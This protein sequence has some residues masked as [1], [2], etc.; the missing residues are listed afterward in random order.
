[1]IVGKHEL[2]YEKIHHAKKPRSR[3]NKIVE[4]TFLSDFQNVSPKFESNSTIQATPLN[5]AMIPIVGSG[6]SL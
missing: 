2:L 1:M 4:R 3:V 5:S 6:A